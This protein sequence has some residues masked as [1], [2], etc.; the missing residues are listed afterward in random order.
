MENQIT[1]LINKYKVII[2]LGSG[3]VGKTTT[4]TA[5]ATAA[6]IQG[7]KVALISIDPAKRLAD[8][9][10]IKLGFEMTKV[11]LPE[12]K[13]ELWAAMLDQ[14]A[15]FDQLVK[16][17]APSPKIYNQIFSNQIYNSISGNLGGPQEY[18]ALAKL[19]EL[20]DGDYDL[21][22]IDTPPD[23]HAID[24]LDKPSIL[25]DFMDKKV[26]NWLIKPFTLAQKMGL[27]KAV[28][29]S[30]K[31]MFGL[32]KV[33]GVSMLQKL[34]EF[35]VLMETTISGLHKSGEK[36][37]NLLQNQ[38]TCFL[39][40]TTATSS[41]TL[42][43]IN[44]ATL[45][46]QYGYQLSAIILNR[47]IPE[48]YQQGIKFWKSS[49]ESLSSMETEFINL[50]KRYLDQCKN[51]AAIEKAIH[52]IFNSQIEVIPI[53]EKRQIVHDLAT[54]IKFSTSLA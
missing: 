27:L 24:F 31:L 6:A 12:S 32:A 44:I 21:I 29:A 38:N 50:E 45:L 14:K 40:V 18:M 4:S 23:T 16:K 46:K 51:T 19:S 35:L 36:I 26:M 5:I 22:V 48:I 53:E 25:S 52:S 2:T 37:I 33:T 47:Q 54:F 10:G 8:A 28:S 43:S 34:A 42:S 3:G 7:K 30:E 13:G 11:R 9:M 49:K 41:G 1:Q 39:L 17:Y 15:V 20:A